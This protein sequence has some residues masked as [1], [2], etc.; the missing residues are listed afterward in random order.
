[1][2]EAIGELFPDAPVYT[3]LH[4]QGSVSQA[5]EARTIHTSLIQ[6]L[7]GS[8]GRYRWYLPLFPWAIEGLDVGGYRLI[9]SSSHCAAKAILPPP[10]TLHLCYCH[11]PMR[12]AWDQFH[13]YFSPERLGRVPYLA[14]RA[15]MA[16]VRRWDRNT[17]ARVDA[18]AANSAFVARR[19]RNY[20]GRGATVIP[21]PVD[22]DWFVPGSSDGPGDYYLVVSAL[23]PYKRVEVAVEAFN[24]MGR[25]LVVVGEGPE[26]G[27]LA[28]LAGPTVGFRG[29]VDETTLRELYQRCR[30]L[31]LPGVE[32]AG[33]VPLEAM[34]CGRPAVV[35]AQGGAA[36]VVRD[37]ET[38]IH[39]PACD[40]D[41]LAAA[42]DRAE[43]VFFNTQVVRTHALEYRRAV[44][45]QRFRE[46]VRRALG[47]GN[48]PVISPPRATDPR[49]KESAR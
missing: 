35:L 5:L 26:A 32:D 27:R 43:R 11:T 39:L 33:I 21:P 45:L 17:A 46:F 38:G 23:V 8:A 30:G 14:V 15:A 19:I 41:A 42:I 40:P 34:A 25:R 22:T 49:S 6:R 44:F 12:Y 47:T 18:F 48:R 36:E 1:M 16:W 10:G 7:P 9:I 28:A 3:L 29:R 37:G 31:V 2:L 13:A 4:L 20:Y 24:R